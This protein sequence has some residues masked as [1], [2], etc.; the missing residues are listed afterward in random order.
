MRI[1]PQLL[2]ALA[3]TTVF[4][5]VELRVESE[6]I[7]SG[8]LLQM[9][10]GPTR[11]TPITTTKFSMDIDDVFGEFEGIAL[12]SQNNDTVG[13][14][15]RQGR[16]FSFFASGQGGFGAAPDYPILTIAAPV[17][18]GLALGTTV[19]INLDLTG[20]F[21]RD[22]LGANYTISPKHGTLTIGGSISIT[23]VIPGG[24]ML[25]AGTN[26]RLLGT[27][28]TAQTDVSGIPGT[29]RFISSTEIDFTLP[30]ATDLRA[31]RI[32]AKNRDNSEAT[33]YSYLRTAPIGTSARALLASAVPLFSS[34]G[35][36]TSAF[37]PA[38]VPSGGFAA[39]A[40][41]NSA[42]S[43]VNVLLELYGG[44]NVR[45]SQ[46]T[47]SMPAASRYSRTV[48][49]IF[50]VALPSNGYVRFSAG[51][52][53]QT[54]G[55][56]GDDSTSSFTVQA[57]DNS[58]AP[59]PPAA[60]LTVSP[61]SLSF[62]AIAGGAAPAPQNITLGVTGNPSS[63]AI[64]SS[65]P[66]LS[67]NIP[68]G[69]APAVIAVSVT[70]NNLPIGTYS[71]TLT[72]SPGL[73]VPVNLT[74]T[75]PPTLNIS[76]T[77]LSFT[78]QV[79]GPPPATQSLNLS[80]G[81]VA[82]NFTITSNAPWLFVNS[83]TGTTPASIPITVNPGA[84]T[85]GTYT[86]SLTVNGTQT[87]PVS[88]TV[89]AAPTLS[90]S[91]AALNFSYQ[92]G[93]AQPAAQTVNVSSSG[94]AAN[95]SVTSSVPWIT[96]SVSSGTAPATV[97]VT[98]NASSFS[99]GNYSGTLTFNGT[100][101]V[102]V[103]LVVAA[104]NTPLLAV[105]PTS[106]S[107]ASQAG[108]AAPAAQN[109]TLSS[110][111]APINFTIASN[112]PWL[113][114]SVSSGTTPAT[115]A[116]SASPS[117][118]SAGVYNGTLTI[119]GAVV[120]AVSLTVS[121]SSALTASPSSLAFAHQLGTSAPTAQTLNLGSTST[122]LPFT[123]SSN[124]A[125]L[126]VN[127]S[128]GTTPATVSVNVNPGGLPAGTYNG[129]LTVGGTLSVPVTLTVSSGP[130]LTA[131]PTSLAFS[132][133]L[134]GPLPS[135]Q[136]LN[137]GSTGTSLPFAI[138][139]N[140]AWLTTSLSGGATPTAVSV[141]ANPAGLA[142]G[143]YNAALTIGGTLTVPVTLT[144]AS[145]PAL[146]ATPSSLAFSI[147]DGLATPRSQTVVVSSTGAPQAFSIASNAS[148]LTTSFFSGTTPST[149]TV[150]V[151]PAGLNPGSYS[152]T[153][154][155]N[156][157][158]PIAV[159]LTIGTAPSITATPSSL[160]FTTQSIAEQSV[161]LVGVPASYSITSNASWLTASPS[162]GIIPATISARV[163]PAGL[164]AGSYTGALS[165]NGAALVTVTLTVPAAPG[166]FSIAAVT[167]A[168]SQS[169]GPLSPGL[170]VSIYGAFPGPAAPAG[171]QLKADGSIDTFVAGTRVLF[172]SIAAPL[173]Y[174][175]NQQINA[176]VPYEVAGA[177]SASI[178]IEFNG[179]RSEPISVALRPSAPAL[180]T[181]NSSGRGQTSALNQDFS[182]N[183]FA[184]PAAPGSVVQL[185]A[186]G[187]GLAE[188]P[189]A[190]GSIN[191]PILRRTLLPV[192]V[193]FNGTRIDPLFAGP[194]PGLAAGVMQVNFLVPFDAVANAATPLT[195]EVGGA[196]SQ[197]GTTIAIR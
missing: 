14:A 89:T 114:A 6:T 46:A 131:N 102:T 110:S 84:L 196:V 53:I 140:A 183:S 66:W 177:T 26:V 153:L 109:L 42:Q 181:A 117:G 32:R 170:L 3:A 194:A 136:T 68:S 67:V 192:V 83:N 126:S 123:I 5:Q 48:Q 174:V 80:S 165:V 149:I 115:I 93:G 105:S 108:G 22:L 186:T 119:N 160:N 148:W 39:V 190:T 92:I 147:T 50:G 161:S 107:F 30:A 184:A 111:G 156:G 100:Q 27:G 99:P 120:V 85:A 125:W 103:G 4:A 129:A 47:V 21:M 121:G 94:G 164:S 142:A 76:P 79:G 124:A 185:F 122:P 133:Q 159:T 33:Y 31:A 154:T 87:V 175:S 176:I 61:A 86:S 15:V 24:G 195:I 141:S 144:V 19:P 172:N 36:T 71:G 168:A 7:P 78:A 88:L 56:I 29:P 128:S 73:T 146:T 55:L 57:F 187:D 17:R 152:G 49:E 10:I 118:L 35:Q 75:V 13:V 9:K 139:S 23:N 137:V 70:A 77:S 116:V 138:T 163:N 182:V 72:I 43:P 157:N 158:L 106:L 81:I 38:S 150:T 16:R 54:V 101:T 127:I 193:V 96:T 130:T 188:P 69:T 25:A 104:G 59:P 145:A 65:A 2:I 179:A 82:Q 1:H 191:P 178:Q 91:P 52:A 167:N 58:A 135:T 40:L 112:A 37:R 20:S 12:F 45:T 143:T 169:L 173:I 180:F 64:T 166:N 90:V 34:R 197:A 162:S 171:A 95:F 44:D 60:A 74:V 11:P 97:S 132:Y 155:I 62:T 41:E 113:A 51:I 18:A 98:V 134:G 28:F 189:S 8:G 151:N 63:F